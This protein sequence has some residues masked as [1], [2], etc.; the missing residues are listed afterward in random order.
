MNVSCFSDTALGR[1]L[2]SLQE[3]IWLPVNDEH[4]R[5]PVYSPHPWRQEDEDL[6]DPREMFAK[7]AR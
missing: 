4:W 2:R 6:E 1:A 7:R 5:N 3:A